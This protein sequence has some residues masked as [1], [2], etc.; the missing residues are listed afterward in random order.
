M[1][2]KHNVKH[3][4]ATAYLACIFYYTRTCARL[5]CAVKFP[6]L[7]LNVDKIHFQVNKARLYIDLKIRRSRRPRRRDNTHVCNH[8]GSSFL[9]NYIL[10]LI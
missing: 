6:Q 3:L 10:A 9:D 1:G 8:L 2:D 4:F 5:K 7:N